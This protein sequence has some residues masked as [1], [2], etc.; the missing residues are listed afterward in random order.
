[1][2]YRPIT[3]VVIFLEA[4]LDTQDV[5]F[6]FHLSALRLVVLCG[7]VVTMALRDRFVSLLPDI[8][9]INLYS[10]SECHDIAVADLSLGELEKVNVFNFS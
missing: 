9:L 6:K 8:K 2:V 3:L 1:M 10:I 7:E 4:V 5:D